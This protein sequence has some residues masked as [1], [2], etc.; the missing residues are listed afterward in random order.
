MKLYTYDYLEKNGRL[1]NQLWQIAATI[2]RAEA[3]GGIARFRPDWEYRSYFNVPDEFF[4]PYNVNDFEEVVDGE[5]NYFQEY[6]YFE[7]IKDQIWKYFQARD[8]EIGEVAKKISN[9]PG[10]GDPGCCNWF[11]SNIALHVRRGD[12]LKYPKHFPKLTARYYQSAVES[13]VETQK[14]GDHEHELYVFSD[15][16]EWC[17]DNAEFLGAT[18]KRLSKVHFVDGVARPVE[19][20]ER[21]GEPQDQWDLFAMAECDHHILSNSTFAW[22]GAY[23]SVDHEP[24]YPDRWFGPGVPNWRNWEKAIPCGWRKFSC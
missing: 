18:N 17:K 7:P 9:S 20:V 22:W 19:V 6:H 14:W 1:G 4:E 3:N 13:I 15:D 8:N 10:C 16:I 24:I 11:I 5:T 2:C 21:V 12:Y 23:L